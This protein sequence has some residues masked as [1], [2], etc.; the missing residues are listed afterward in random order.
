MKDIFG[1]GGAQLDAD[2]TMKLLQCVVQAADRLLAWVLIGA[3]VTPLFSLNADRVSVVRYQS[4]GNLNAPTADQVQLG[5]QHA[6][7]LLRFI[8]LGAAPVL[9]SGAGESLCV[10]TQAPHGRH[11]VRAALQQCRVPPR[12]DIGG[13]ARV[14]GPPGDEP[15]QGRS[16]YCS[17]KAHQRG[18][19][20][21]RAKIA[22]QPGDS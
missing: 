10:V 6:K 14:A 15:G 21:H 5:G 1:V 13:H 8:E 7:L 2:S 22:L 3:R 18:K 20:A 12:L 19:P 17:D 16:H 4:G 11:E 9:I